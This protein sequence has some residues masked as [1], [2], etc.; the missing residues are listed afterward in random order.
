M[1]TL[2]RTDSVPTVLIGGREAEVVFS[3][4]TPQF[5]GVNQLNV[6]VPSGLSAASAVPIQLRVGDITTTD[7]A[8]MAI[9]N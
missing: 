9:G 8:T 4:L 6:V 1:D 5:V 7:L 2:R 3:G